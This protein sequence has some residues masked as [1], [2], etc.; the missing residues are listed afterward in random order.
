MPFVKILHL[1]SGISFARW[2]AVVP[3]SRKRLEF[4]SIKAAAFCAITIFASV[5][6]VV[7]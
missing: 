4:S 3:P 7:F 6:M 5:L 2:I 1:I